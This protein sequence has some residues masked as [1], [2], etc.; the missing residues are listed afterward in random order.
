MISFQLKFVLFIKF[1]FGIVDVSVSIYKATYVSSLSSE[2][3]HLCQ[4]DHLKT[5]LGGILN[6]ACNKAVTEDELASLQ[7]ILVKLLLHFKGLE[8]VLALVCFSHFW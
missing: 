4:E 5:I 6:L 8:D 1:A 3:Y 7:T 2:S